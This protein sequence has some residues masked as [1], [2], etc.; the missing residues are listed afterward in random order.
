[1]NFKVGNNQIYVNS[2]SPA[3]GGS[4]SPDVSF[5]EVG[6]YMPSKVTVGVPDDTGKLK[7]IN[8]GDSGNC[9]IVVELEGDYYLVWSDNVNNG[10]AVELGITITFSKEA[11]KESTVLNL[12]FKCGYLISETEMAITGEI[13]FD[14]YVF[15]PVIDWMQYAI[16]GGIAVGVLIIGY[17]A[18]RKPKQYGYGG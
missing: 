18:I 1:M 6:C 13:S 5:I 17:M 11:F 8:N 4:L 9:A 14:I 7:I 10:E 3:L 2:V 15:V 16:I 12:P